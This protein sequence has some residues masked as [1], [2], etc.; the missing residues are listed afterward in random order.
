[1]VRQH[2]RYVRHVQVPFCTKVVFLVLKPTAMALQRVGNDPIGAQEPG[3]GCNMLQQETKKTI[4]GC[5]SDC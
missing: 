5:P 4:C 1:M 2:P 3:R